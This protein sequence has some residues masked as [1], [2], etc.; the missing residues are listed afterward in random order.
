MS[1]GT[2]GK[3][4]KSEKTYMHGKIMDFEKKLEL[5]WKNDGIL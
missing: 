2:H 5:S 1:S 3:P 4:G